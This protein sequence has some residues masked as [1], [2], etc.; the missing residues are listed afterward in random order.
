MTMMLGERPPELTAAGRPDAESEETL[1]DVAEA[2]TDTAVREFLSRL[3]ERHRVREREVAPLQRDVRDGRLADPLGPAFE[4]AAR[5][6]ARGPSRSS[7]GSA[8]AGDEVAAARPT[9]RSAV[10]ACVAPRRD[11]NSDTAPL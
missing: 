9:S 7:C 6:L 2:D 1:A 5:S 4:V 11:P 10:S 3:N 8:E